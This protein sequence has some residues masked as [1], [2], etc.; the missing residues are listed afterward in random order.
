M[1]FVLLCFCPQT[2]G[3][4]DCSPSRIYFAPA[5]A[6]IEEVYDLIM[7]CSLLCFCLQRGG[8]CACCGATAPPSP[9]SPS[10]PQ[11]WVAKPGGCSESSGCAAGA[12]AAHH[13]RAGAAAGAAG[14]AGAAAGACVL[15]LKEQEPQSPGKKVWLNGGWKV[16]GRLQALGLSVC[17]GSGS[18]C[19]CGGAGH[20]P[21]AG[22]AALEQ[23]EELE[24]QQVCDG[25]VCSQR[26]A[27]W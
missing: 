6:C 27:P 14:G 23:Q 21:G 13:P 16:P 11:D 1:T 2:G 25:V 26:T 3:Q 4:H 12:G 19:V 22:A 17:C 20:H 8:Q 10:A 9:S 7:T 18:G 15:V 24:W 5:S